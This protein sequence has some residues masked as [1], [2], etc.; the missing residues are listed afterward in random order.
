MISHHHM[1]IIKVSILALLCDC[2]LIWRVIAKAREASEEVAE[3]ENNDN[4][5]LLENGVNEKSDTENVSKNVIS[6]EEKL[7]DEITDKVEVML[8]SVI[9]LLE[10]Q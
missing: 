7:S 3:K 6:D 4:D 5:E 9:K 2:C 1:Y 8:K 10:K